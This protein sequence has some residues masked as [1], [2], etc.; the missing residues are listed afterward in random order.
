MSEGVRVWVDGILIESGG[1]ALSPIDHGVTVGDGVFE[2]MKIVDGQA[3]ALT[4]HLR[5]LDRSL[6]GLG[7]DP[8]DHDHVR[9]GVEAV[10]A[11]DAIP[12]GRLRVT[13]TAGVGP[14]GSDRGDAAMTYVVAAGAAPRPTPTVRIATVPWTRNETSAVAGLKTTS[15]AENVVALARA[16]SLGAADAL[17]GNTK[18]ELCECTGSNVF[19]VLDGVVRTP[20]LESGCLAGITRELTIEWAREAGIEV[21][22]EAMPLD[23]VHRA[24]EVFLT[25]TTRDVHPVAAVDDR[26]LDAPG[27]VTARL[28]EIFAQRA[29][30]R[31]DP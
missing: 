8:A 1:L 4:R 11:G 9:E 21:R 20:P 14:L 16:K 27:P 3:F 28:A 17:F 19:V 26:E 6:L 23:V 12:F 13:V 30:E 22:E 10:L 5:R 29:S 31:L 7:L 25:G 15:Y 2:T 24:E 18:G